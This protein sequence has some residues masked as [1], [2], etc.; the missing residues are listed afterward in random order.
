[1]D[2]S[3]A[4]QDEVDIGRDGADAVGG[5]EP[6]PRG[7]PPKQRWRG[8]RKKAAGWAAFV[9][10]AMQELDSLAVRTVGSVDRDSLA[11]V[12]EERNHDLSASLKSNLLE[13][14]SRSGIT[15][16]CRLSISNLESYVC[17][18]LASK[19]T[20]LRLGHEHHLDM[21]SFL[22]EVVVGNH[23]LGN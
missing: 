10:V 11:L 23:I 2:T 18:K 20:L 6:R 22:H 12:D 15:L 5:T 13:S 7:F 16:Y 14:R 3:S 1:M 4:K 9:S 8:E 17:R 21:L 19:A